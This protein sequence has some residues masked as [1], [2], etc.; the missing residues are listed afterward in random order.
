MRKAI[1]TSLAAGFLAL[2][3]GHALAAPDGFIS[4]KVKPADTLYGLTKDY[5]VNAAALEEVRRINRVRNPRLMQIGKTLRIPR[6]LLKH[7][8]ARLS[9]ESFSGRV[10][11][12]NGRQTLAAKRGLALLEGVEIT[13]GRNSFVAIAGDGNSSVSIPSNS[14]VRIIDARRYL[15]N[16]QIDV[17]LRVL[18]G[19]GEVIA[20]TIEGDGRYRVGTPIAVTAV[21]GTGFRVGFLP[22]GDLSLTEVV[23]GE[24]FVAA[25]EEEQ[26]TKAGFGLAARQ[27]GLGEQ[28]RLLP[29]PELIDPGRIQTDALARFAITPLEGAVGYR[30]QISRDA[31]FIDIV[32]ELVDEAQQADFAEIE[33]GR[34][35]VRTR[36][37]SASGLEG[38]SKVHSFRRKRA[39]VE[40]SAEPSGLE[41]AFKFAWRAQGE[42]DVYYGFQLWNAEEESALIVDE[43]GMR[44]T[45]VLVSKLA[46]GTYRWRVASF[47]IDEGDVIKVWG[48][49]QELSIT[50]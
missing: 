21:R 2:T 47:Q 10:S 9:V 39:G 28:E 45:A 20:P 42:G 30:T 15:I 19:R 44:E 43:V 3:P 46:P 1:L 23:E 24:V 4:Y 50:E 18:E 49:V 48:P 11:L 6:R 38:F 41:D 31:G 14:R 37:V 34:Y 36:A 5:L 7:K 27:D 33:D 40:A 29:A 8:P 13:T 25:G 35:F 32:T 12:V 26:A 17:Q 22:D 16:D